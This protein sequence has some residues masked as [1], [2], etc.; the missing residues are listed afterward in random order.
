[1]AYQEPTETNTLAAT[2]LFIAAIVSDSFTATDPADP[3]EAPTSLRTTAIVLVACLASPPIR[4]WMVFEQRLVTSVPLGIVALVGW[5]EA[6]PGTRI[7]DA[8]YVTAT[9][10]ACTFAFWANGVENAGAQNGPGAKRPPKSKS[11]DAPPYL[12]REALAN[13]A[14]ACLFYGSFRVLRLGIHSPEAARTY[15]VSSAAFDGTTQETVGYAY[16]SATATIALCFGGA[17][18]VGTAVVLMV[19]KDMRTQ[20]TAAATVVLCASAFMQLTA[21]FVSSMAFSEGLG[22][23]VGIWSR[24][25]CSSLELCLPAWEARRFA[26]VSST[27]AALW[28]TGLGTLIMAFAP[29][30][31]LRTR[32]QA[33]SARKDFETTVY[34]IV[35]LLVCELTLFTY[36]SFTGSEAL[37]DY[38]AVGALFAIGLGAFVDSLSGA[39]VFVLCVGGDIV[40]MWVA[41]GAVDVFGHFTHCSNAS[42][43]ILLSLYVV[44]VAI[45]EFF[46][47]WM[48]AELIDVLDSITGFLATIGTSI[49]AL[50]YCGTVALQISYDGQ[51]IADEQYRG[52]DNRY[53]R[54]AAAAI[55]EHWLPLLIWLPL[56]GCRCEV[57]QL[58]LRIRAVVWYLAPL[59]PIVAWGLVLSVNQQ[60]VTHAHGW[61]NDGAFITSVGVVALAPWAALV[62]S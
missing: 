51:L 38:A 3:Y 23:L 31:R 18:G 62:W 14:T 46:W 44:I 10:G 48:P 57:E 40:Q 35:A 8:M 49:A 2:V 20:G 9:L 19:N 39:F 26:T 59:V 25:A 21:A 29:T 12:R 52:A 32:A 4:Q 37:T 36:L 11:K 54:T 45:T 43:C 5:H 13:L 58:E 55:M 7:A 33:A 42:M 27:G 1:M 50:L 56:Y 6:G 30:L 15:T 41:H 17:A 34:A 61:Y 60:A 47:R 22:T 28:L 53:A 24:G 16:L